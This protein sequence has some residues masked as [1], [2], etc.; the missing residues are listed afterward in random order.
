MLSHLMNWPNMDS[1]KECKNDLG[2]ISQQHSE[3]SMCGAPNV[4]KHAFSIQCL[5]LDQDHGFCCR[6]GSEDSLRLL[7]TDWYSSNGLLILAWEMLENWR[8]YMQKEF[9]ERS[10]M[11]IS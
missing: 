5:G 11:V 9:W 4:F 10:E 8:W 2:Q 7:F 3:S 6:S 1:R